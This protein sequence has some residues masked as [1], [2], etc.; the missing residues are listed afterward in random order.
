[1]ATSLTTLFQQIANAIREKTG[2]S[3][4][5]Q[6]ANF[7]TAISNIQSGGAIAV[8]KNLRAGQVTS[9]TFPEL[10]GCE[11]V[12]FYQRRDQKYPTAVD[13]LG[14]FMVSGYITPTT[15]DYSYCQGVSGFAYGD[16]K[17]RVVWDKTTG[18]LTNNDP[19]YKFGTS[20]YTMVFWI[21]GW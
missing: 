9:L 11:N 17:T 16:S 14:N 7:P 13:S 20:G 1:M 2:D 6:A 12:V 18:T 4:T 5:I 19:N 21:F 10:V 8:S 15:V 3:A